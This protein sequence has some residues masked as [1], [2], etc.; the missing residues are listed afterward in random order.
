MA[1]GDT[2]SSTSTPGS[3]DLEFHEA[4]ILDQQDADTVSIGQATTIN[5]ALQVGGSNVVVE[6]TAVGNELQTM[7][8]TVGNTVTA[9]ALDNLPSIWTRR[10][11]VR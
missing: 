4:R 2:S 3:Y 6:V 7:N 5:M 8:A 9:V 11:H 1:R 10:E